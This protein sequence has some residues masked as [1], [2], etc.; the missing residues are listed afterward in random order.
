MR[1]LPVTDKDPLGNY[2]RMHLM[3]N[4]RVLLS[5]WHQE[6]ALFNRP[7]PPGAGWGP[8]STELAGRG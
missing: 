7:G 2:P 8:H 5:G 1:R 3:P 6:T 4:G